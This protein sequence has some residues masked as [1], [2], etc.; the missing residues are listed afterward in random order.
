[1]GFRNWN[2]KTVPV[3]RSF[4][5]LPTDAK[6]LLVTPLFFEVLA[7]EDGGVFIDEESAIIFCS[8]FYC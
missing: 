5:R 3:G 2:T 8:S 6:V 4:M 7:E 1:M